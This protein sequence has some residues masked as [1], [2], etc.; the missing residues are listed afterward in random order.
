MG[1]KVYFSTWMVEFYGINVGKCTSPMDAMGKA[2]QRSKWGTCSWY[3]L[4]H[5]WI[6]HKS[7]PDQ[8]WK[9]NKW[10]SETTILHPKFNSEICPLKS[11][12]PKTQGFSPHS[13]RKNFGGLKAWIKTTPR[14]RTRIWGNPQRSLKKW[15]YPIP[16][17][18]HH[19]LGR[20]A[21]DGRIL[22]LFMPAFFRAKFI[23]PWPSA[24]S[25]TIASPW[26]ISS[27]NTSDQPRAVW[28]FPCY[29]PSR[30]LT[31][32]ILEKGKNH[33]QTCLGIGICHLLGG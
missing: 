3:E 5:I 29:L 19:F 15:D 2:Q 1:R 21:S 25:Q 22:K 31:D 28:S 24:G 13:L 11:S 27:Q 23:H 12:A 16:V 30:E 7:T 4:Y 6:D 10:D 20:P 9:K 18:T 14:G 32:P 17:E 26:K 8:Y 33:L